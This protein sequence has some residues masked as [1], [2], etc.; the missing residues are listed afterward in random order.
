VV[1]SANIALTAAAALETG[2]ALYLEHVF[3]M[4]LDR[5]AKKEGTMVTTHMLAPDLWDEPGKRRPRPK[6]V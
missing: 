1:F 2:R 6:K 3:M 4:A 5:K